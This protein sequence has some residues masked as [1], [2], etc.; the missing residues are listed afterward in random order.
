MTRTFALPFPLILESGGVLEEV[1]VA[2]RTWGKLDAAGT[3]AVLV[4][5]ALTGNA[6]ADEWWEPL[7][8]SGRALDPDRDFILCSNILGSCYGT[9][10]PSSYGPGF[11]RITVRDIVAVQRALVRHL[12]VRRLR[13]VIGGSFGG[14]QVLEWALSA[15]DLVE[16]IAPIATSGR[17]SPWTIAWSE[18]QRQAIALDPVRGLAV[19][20][21]IAMSTYR[22]HGSYGSRFGRAHQEGAFHVENWLRNHGQRLVDRFDA[23]TYVTLTHAMDS[24][25]VARGRGAYETVLGSI[26]Q[27][28]FIVSIDSD[29]LYP[30]AEQEELA[31]LIPNATLRTISSIHGHDG[32]L[33]DAAAI[34]E[35]LFEWR[36]RNAAAPARSRAAPARESQP[37]P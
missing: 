28:T 29:V 30:P 37:S 21:M 26:R 24:H 4:C 18:A 1:A 31:V 3:N 32:F 25:D 14:M 10:G 7:I 19:A 6:D 34:N 33:I 11:P 16:T 23:A 35:V 36:F 9:T 20:R 17:H 13:L 12:G 8:G 2:Y 22:S 15:P 27:P 5:H